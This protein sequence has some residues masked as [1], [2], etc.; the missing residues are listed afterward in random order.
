MGKQKDR[1]RSSSSGEG[2][3]QKQATRIKNIRFN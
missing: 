2:F 1:K 3:C